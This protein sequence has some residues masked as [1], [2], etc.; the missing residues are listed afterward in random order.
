MEKLSVGASN[1]LSGD[2]HILIDLTAW[3][4]DSLPPKIE[5]LH[6]AILSAHK[7]SFTYF[8]PKGNSVR[9]IEPYNLL[10]YWSSW[11][12][13]GWCGK[14]EDYRLFK[15]SRMVDIQITEPFEK[16]IAPL[17]DLSSE[18]VFPPVYKVTARIDPDHKWRLVE[19]YG[20]D[21][22]TVQPDGMLLFSAGFTDRMSIV[23][24]IVSFGEGAELLEPAEF[25]QDI[26]TFAEKIREKYL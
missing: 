3:Q 15:L 4:K 2:T 22:F 25:R 16:R 8:A 19:E 24:W 18:R 26:R 1:L 6:G 12:V 21:S 5:L 20:P 14:R 7:V 11:Y 10:F 17:P 13:W 23:G 9:S